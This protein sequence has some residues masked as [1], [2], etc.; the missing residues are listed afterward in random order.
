MGTINLISIITI[1]LLGSFGHCLG[2]CGGIVVAYSSAKIEEGQTVSE[3]FIRHLLYSLGRVTTYV[4][5]GVFFGFLGGVVTFGAKTYGALY[6]V[7]GVAMIAMGFS[8]L[9]YIKSLSSPTA[10]TSSKLFMHWF[11]KM[12]Q[13]KTILSFYGLGVLNG[14]IPCGLVYFFEIT[15]ASTGSPFWGGIV[16]AIFGISTIPA[17]MTFAF[18]MDFLKKSVLR[19]WFYRI[20]G[21][22][23]ILYGIYT[24]YTAYRFFT[25]PG[26][27]LHD[28][29]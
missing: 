25:V 10:L 16:M 15:A 23:I 7:A 5:M 20:A 27:T 17:L 26:I 13:S 28:C 19:T 4:V 14:F 2:M 9:G 11:R 8:V 22:T 12:L 29:H 18:V 24:L 1:A 6:V 21:A 3:R